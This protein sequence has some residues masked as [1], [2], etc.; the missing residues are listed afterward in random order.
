M[1]KGK[2]ARLCTVG[3]SAVCAVLL[4]LVLPAFAQDWI[5]TGTGLG[6]EKVRLAVPDFKPSTQDSKNAELLKVFNDT[7]WNDL[8]TAGIFDLVS[9]S[10]YPTDFPGAPAEMKFEAWN[11]PPPNASMVAFGNLGI[12]GTQVAVQGWLYDVKNITSPQVLGKQYTDAATTDA[13]RLIA[14]K[15][16]D[17]IIFRMGGGVQGVAETKIY[18]VSERGGHKEIWVMDYDGANQHAV[19]HLGSISLSPRISPDGSRLAFSSLTKTG[20]E[21][22]MYSIDL[23]RMVAFPHFGGTNLSPAWSP[24]GTKLAFSGSRSGDSQIYIA[25]ASGGNLRRLTNGRGPDVSP[26]W[27]KKTG[28]QIAFVSGRTGLPQIYTMEADGTNVQKMTDQGYAVSPQWSP[29]GQFLAFSWMRKYGPGMPGSNDLYLMDIASKQWVQLTHDGSRN[30]FPSWSPDN[31][32]IVFQSN[33]SGSEQIWT[34]LADG[35]KLQQLTFTGKNSQP[36]WTWK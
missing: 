7:L 36:N 10:F 23:G 14:H 5:R 9:K 30:D 22:L 21:I 35:T 24:D 26:S 15:F 16:A 28:A 4:A 18:F 1:K 6:V 31:R 12:T 34:M 2:I 19:T 17:E 3:F 8:D 32:H 20:W 13:A 29:N 33:R 11:A 25:D 27:N